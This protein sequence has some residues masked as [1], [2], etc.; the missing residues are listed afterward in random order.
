[1]PSSAL[2][3]AAAAC[4]S[5]NSKDGSGGFLYEG[6]LES[7][8]ASARSSDTNLNALGTVGVGRS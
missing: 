4:K 2:A 5:S 6:I 1:M 3:A 8:F 7:F